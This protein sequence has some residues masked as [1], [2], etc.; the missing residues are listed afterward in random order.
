MKARLDFQ[1]ASQHSETGAPN[2]RKDLRKNLEYKRHRDTHEGS[3]QRSDRSRSPRK[4]NTE[5]ETVFKRLEKGVFHRLRDWER[6][7]SMYSG[8]SKRPTRHSAQKGEE[9]YYHISY[10][11]RTGPTT[12]KH[13]DNRASSRKTDALFESKDSGGGHPRKKSQVLRTTT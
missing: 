3:I 8:D 12:R 7:I 6:S 5:R 2:E 4:K 1:E 10:S 11:Q 13:G 9:S